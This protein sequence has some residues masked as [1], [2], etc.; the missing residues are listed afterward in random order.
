MVGSSIRTVTGTASSSG[1][2]AIVAAVTGRRIVVTSYQVYPSGAVSVKFRSA[3][4]DLHPAIPLAGTSQPVGLGFGHNPHGYFETTAGEALNL[5][6][7]SAVGTVY[8]VQ[9]MV[10]P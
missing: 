5:N 6:L 2:N 9:Y 10:R 3:A 4:N 8:I 1:D 7:S